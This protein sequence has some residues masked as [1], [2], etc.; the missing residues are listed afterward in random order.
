MLHPETA[1]GRDNIPFV[2]RA[3][4]A[5]SHGIDRADQGPGILAHALPVA[6][7]LSKDP[8]FEPANEDRLTPEWPGPRDAVIRSG[9]VFFETAAGGAVLSVE[10]MSFIGALPIDNHD[11]L[12]ARFLENVLR[13]FA[14]P[15][16]FTWPQPSD[17]AHSDGKSA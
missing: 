17:A 14:D 8:S 10:S 16:S 11:N 3:A 5:A 1:E 6:A 9:L 13:R 7:G 15:T 4:H 12:S 2:V